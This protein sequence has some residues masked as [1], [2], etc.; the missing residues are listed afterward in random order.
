[1][2]INHYTISG[3]GWTPITTSGTSGSCWLKDA[4]EGGGNCVVYHSSSG[5]PSVDLIDYGK[6]VYKSV[7]NNDVCNITADSS[8]DIYYAMIDN[9]EGTCVIISDYI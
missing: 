1:M 5:I 4:V 9:E 2:A 8:N 6:K 3:T 7:R